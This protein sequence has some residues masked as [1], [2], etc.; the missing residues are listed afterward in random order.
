MGGV[1]HQRGY[2]RHPRHRRKLFIMSRLLFRRTGV[3]SRDAE[4]RYYFIPYHGSNL[5]RTAEK[6]TTLQHVAAHACSASAPAGGREGIAAHGRAALHARCGVLLLAAC[7]LLV[8][9]LRVFAMTATQRGNQLLID[10][11]PTP[12]TFA[13]NCADPGHAPAIS[14]AR[15]QY[16][17]R[18]RFLFG[19]R[20]DK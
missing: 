20:A 6:M 4:K 9:P 17:D 16:G 14:C 3:L 11:T 7:L 15:F 8:L 12:L 2:C 5:S 1:Y 18:P 13:W 19:H 10:G